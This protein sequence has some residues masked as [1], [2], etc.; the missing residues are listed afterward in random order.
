MDPE[1]LLKPEMYVDL[2]LVADL[3]EAVSVPQEAVMFTGERAIVFVAQGEG[4]F[5]PREVKLGTQA[6]NFYEVKTGL[7]L[8]E[9]IAVSGN[10]LIDSESRLQSALEGMTAGGHIHGS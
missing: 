6:G 5:E 3:G 4:F 8:G 9:Q 2:F 1:K 10:F 7:H